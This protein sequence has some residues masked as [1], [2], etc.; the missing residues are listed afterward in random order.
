MRRYLA[1][2]IAGVLA[3]SGC[4]KADERMRDY[5][6][7]N[8]SGDFTLTDQDGAV[9]HLKDHRGQIILLFFGYTMCPDICPVTFSR[10]ARVYKH[11]GPKARDVLTVFVSVDVDRDTP[12]RLKEYLQYFSINAVGLTGTREEIDAVVDAYKGSYEKV[13]SESAAGYLYDHSDY[14]YLIGRDGQLRYLFHHE[15][16]PEQMASVIQKIEEN[17]AP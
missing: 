7:L 1:L 16:T 6:S 15:D 14:V 11:L 2:V 9:F 13:E 17:Q 5:S 3:V 12:S 8:P 10:L 4:Q